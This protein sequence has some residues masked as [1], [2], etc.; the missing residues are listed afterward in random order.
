M[1]T[2]KSS[3]GDDGPEQT[4]ELKQ[5]FTFLGLKDN[6]SKRKKQKP[7]KSKPA[8]R[9]K[10]SLMPDR[11]LMILLEGQA[12]IV[13]HS[14]QTGAKQTVETLVP[15]DAINLSP[16]LQLPMW[17]FFGNIEASQ[18]SQAKLLVVECPDLV[19]ELFERQ[20]M[21]VQFDQ[22]TESLRQKM[23]GRFRFL[24]KYK[25]IYAWQQ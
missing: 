11:P 12:N 21:K 22:A 23:E 7:A 19:L 14:P 4:S 5:M 25:N 13:F 20:A 10:E 3:L 8:T 17:E 1:Q 18:Q 24:P 16:L 15:G 2:I 9:N 6:Y